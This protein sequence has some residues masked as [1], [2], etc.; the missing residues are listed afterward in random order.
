MHSRAPHRRF[1]ALL[2]ITALWLLVAAPVISQIAQSRASYS[3]LGM[4]CDGMADHAGM[5]MP[6]HAGKPHPDRGES[7]PACGYCGLFAHAAAVPGAVYVAMFVPSTP[8]W[9]A[10]L[11]LSPLPSTPRLLDAAPRG[12]PMMLHA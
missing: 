8:H 2:A 12:P 11:P 3:E 1:V 5:A 7:M 9:A 10:P 6:E 4:H